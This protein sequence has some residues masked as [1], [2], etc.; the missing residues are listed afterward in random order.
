MSFRIERNV[1]VPMR[2]GVTLATDLWIPDGPPAPVLLVR[3][4]YGKDMAASSPLG[5]SILQLLDAGYAVAWQD[6]R[7]TFRSDGE[8]TPHVDDPDDGTDTIAWLREQPWCDGN[9][10]GYGA[11]YLGFV[12]WASASRSPAGLKAIAPMV[13]TTDYHLTPWYSE[14][15]AVSWHTMWTWVTMQ[16]LAAAQKA[17][18]A[19]AGDP[20]T[21]MKL[22]DMIAHPQSH[23]DTLP[24]SDQPLL[25]KQSPWWLDWLAHPDRDQ[26]WQDMAVAE[27]LNQVT[28]P[29]LNVG[30]WFDLFIGGT[31]RT[32]TRMRAE[33]GS[34]EAREG[35]RLIIGPWDHLTWDG[36]YPD[37]QFPMAASAMAAD[38][39]GE[40]IRFFDRWLRGSSAALDGR[41]P[42]RIFVMGIDQWR[43]EQDWPLPGTRYTSYYLHGAGKA[44]TADGDGG[45]STEPPAAAAADTYTYDPAS[46]VPSLGGR[47]MRPVAI[48]GAGPADQRPV[49]ARQDVLCYSTPVL[50]G[51]VEVTGHVALVLHVASSA[52]DTDFTGKLVDV[53]PDGRAIY[54]TD[55][56]LRAR[57]RDSLAE[58]ELLEPG[59]AYEVT[60]DLSV[61]SNVFLPGHRIRLEVSSSNFPRYDR[62]TNTG[63]VIS[64]D[65]AERAVAATNTILHGPE[66]PSRL[67]LPVIGS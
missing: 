66:H 3:L 23:L 2:D 64:Q 16:T 29:A 49:E 30:G 34:A 50:T 37:R 47:V 27:N 31:T 19:G 22:S 54:L 24:V 52:R 12:Q 62:N 44:H 48:N 8:F 5:P 28:T 61:T 32:F 36:T 20:G 33:A 14:G 15:G 57:Y 59:K 4:P 6:C 65:S 17:L 18:A 26:F 40:H 7:G 1:M 67:V 46:P 45:L 51:Q 38:L 21:L 60:L 58:P 42:V 9:I 63:G 35:Q 13:T 11:S 56:I 25:A 10:G 41:A 55:G 43:D 39:T 53:F